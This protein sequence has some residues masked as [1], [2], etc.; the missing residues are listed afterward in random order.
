MDGN[1]AVQRA[2]TWWESLSSDAASAGPDILAG[3]ITDLAHAVEDGSEHPVT[4][5]TGLLTGLGE[6]VQSRAQ[7]LIDSA[8]VPV[9]T[10]AHELGSMAKNNG[11]SL[12]RVADALRHKTDGETVDGESLDRFRMVF[13]NTAVAIAVATGAIDGTIVEVNQAFADMFSTTVERVRGVSI[14]HF[15]D[16][17]KIGADLREWVSLLRSGGGSRRFEAPYRLPDGTRR[18]AL[19]IMTFVSH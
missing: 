7:G 9:Q 3:L 10:I 16:D 4:K 13:D 17:E 5:V 1:D 11:Q 2:T 14:S 18:W 19:F 15:A 12:L 8:A 6:L